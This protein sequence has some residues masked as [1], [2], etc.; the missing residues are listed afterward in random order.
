MATSMASTARLTLVQRTRLL[1]KLE[2]LT[3]S[4]L[5]DAAHFLEIEITFKPN[6]E[7]II[8]KIRDSLNK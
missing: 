7:E 8:S 5:L 4:Q 3:R 6:R 2:T 1:S